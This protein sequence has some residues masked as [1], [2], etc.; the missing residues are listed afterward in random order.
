[1]IVSSPGGGQAG[2]ARDGQHDGPGEGGHGQGPGVARQGDLLDPGEPER[3]SP[4]D[5]H[6][7]DQLHLLLVEEGGYHD[8]EPTN[9]NIIFIN[10]TNIYQL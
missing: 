7:Q 6:D 4:A 3:A 10:F 5:C 1:M 2:R 8:A 9:G